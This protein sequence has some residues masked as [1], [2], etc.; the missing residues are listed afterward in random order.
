[1][2]NLDHVT[3]CSSAQTD[4]RLWNNSSRESSIKS[5]LENEGVLDLAV[6]VP[7]RQNRYE[8]VH[9]YDAQR[10]SRRRNSLFRSKRKVVYQVCNMFNKY[11]VSFIV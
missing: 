8:L 5:W 11:S 6:R 10:S 7:Y 1:M 3:L 9:Y 4:M 2:L